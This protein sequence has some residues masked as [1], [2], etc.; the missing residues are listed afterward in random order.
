MKKICIS[1]VIFFITQGLISCS[2]D[3]GESK[4]GNTPAET[5]APADSDRTSIQVSPGGVEVEN[6]SGNKSTEV[7][8]SADSLKFE[9]EKKK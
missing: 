7:K 9:R 6:K 5:R 3:K 2:G 4:N 8:I 1:I